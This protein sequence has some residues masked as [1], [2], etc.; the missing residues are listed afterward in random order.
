MT[1]CT[2]GQGH[3]TFG[4]CIRAKNL[5]VGYCQSSRGLDATSERSKDRELADYAAAR[6]Q[7][8]QPKSTFTRD[9]R[10]AMDVSERTGTAFDAAKG[11]TPLEA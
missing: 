10:D 4:A 7:G 6:R 2:C 1:T 5:R 3:E 8:V 9:I 11:T